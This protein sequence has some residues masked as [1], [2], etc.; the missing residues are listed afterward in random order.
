MINFIIEFILM[1]TNLY[2][3]INQ[4]QNGRSPKISYILVG[5]SLMLILRDIHNLM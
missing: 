4:E 5:A 1:C 3:G 2:I